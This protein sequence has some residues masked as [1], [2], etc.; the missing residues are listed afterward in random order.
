MYNTDVSF[1]KVTGQSFIKL[2]LFNHCVVIYLH[3]R[4]SWP[5]SYGSW[6]YTYL[7]NQCLSPL[8]LWVW[9]LLRRGVPNTT[10]CD[11]VC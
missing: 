11:E 4:L 8:T 9:I 2:I 1:V 10:L 5:W 6:I 7:C 3:F